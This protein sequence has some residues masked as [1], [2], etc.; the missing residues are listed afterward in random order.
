M[1]LL[2]WRRPT[3]TIF[4]RLVIALLMVI[5]PLYGIGLEMNKL[6]ETSV[7]EELSTSLQ[8]RVDFYL[9]SLDTENVHLFSLLQ[10]YIVDKDLQRLAFVSHTMSIAEWADTVTQIQNKLQIIK[11]SS[12]YVKSVSAH[13]A[14]IGRTLST[15]K[16]ISDLLDD[17]FKA[18]EPVFKLKGPRTYYWEGRLFLAVA[19]PGSDLPGMKQTFLLS[20]ELNLDVMKTAL[21]SFFG[22]AGAGAALVQ[23][24]QGWVVAAIQSAGD[25]A[26]LQNYVR[27][28]SPL[29][30]PEAVDAAGS[31]PEEPASSGSDSKLQLDNGVFMAACQRSGMLG[32]TL[33]A[34]VP[35]EKMLG[36]LAKYRTM[37]WLLS[38]LSFFVV[39][40]HSYWIYRL[41]HK[42]LQRMIAAF[43]KVEAGNLE[44]VPLPRPNNE[45]LYLFERFNMMTEK[46]KVLIH[47][48][49]EQN[50]RAKSSELKQLQSQ[51]NPHFLYNTYFILY[52]LAK[53]NDNESVVR[54]SQHL[55]EYFQ[56]ITRNAAEEATLAAE[57]KHSR[58][59][60]EIQ[61]IRFAKSRIRVDFGELPDDCAGQR[62]PRLFLQPIIE[63]AYKYGLE[64]KRKN[65][66]I[67][68]SFERR[69][70]DLLIAV[71]DNGD[72][73]SDEDLRRLGD[74]L[75]SR[76]KEMEYTGMLNVHRRLQ[77]RFGDGYGISVARGE[78][79]GLKVTIRLPLDTA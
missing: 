2:A 57:C 54:F 9:Q 4:P 8:T 60:A 39:L 13:I 56:Y 70:G 73:L 14:T 45:F 35:Q 29:P 17:D 67:D 79:G 12:L 72:Q 18:V 75:A 32:Y 69:D 62:V 1:A 16:T 40:V 58:T 27:L 44:P 43:R 22:Q 78:L 76:S 52:R 33:I 50:I 36:P 28:H 19:Y 41:I 53:M 71:A 21:Q 3:S 38:I 68:V 30:D 34:F 55:G 61:N 6:G 64:E 77:I 31:A 15:E 26:R 20:I 47:E 49:Y 23:T 63:N 46:L 66:R 37:L 48:V 10:Q 24:E 11:S 51:I 7:R 42:P 65:G 59:Y 74:R 5:A 25:T